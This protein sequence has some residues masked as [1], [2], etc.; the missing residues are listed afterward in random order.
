MDQN[1]R[2]ED[3]LARRIEL[4]ANLCII[5]V[6]LIGATILAKRFLFTS[7]QTE[8]A[9]VAA[10]AQ[11]TRNR[12]TGPPEGSQ[13]SLP[14]VDW[15]K[16]GETVLLVLSNKCHFCTESAPFYKRLAR[17]LSQ[18]RD[19][20]I[21]AVFPQDINEAKEYLGKLE[22]P[23]EEV[24]QARLDSVG[25]RGTPTLVIVDSTGVVKHVWVGRLTTEKESEVLSLV[26]I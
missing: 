7:P 13:L 1:S 19:V 5:I 24:K 6:A 22:V 21:V 10:A 8:V 4:V 23:I 14:G 3:S 12:G 2:R 9:P 18:R 15:A 26:K 17:E 25:I 16:N 20:Q 11:P